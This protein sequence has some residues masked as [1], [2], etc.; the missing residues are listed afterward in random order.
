MTDTYAVYTFRITAEPGHSLTEKGYDA[1][2]D[3]LDKVMDDA[4]DGVKEK[5]SA[6]LPMDVEDAIH[7]AWKRE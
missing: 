1:L 2:E 5:L 6:E 3:A 7:V 4:L